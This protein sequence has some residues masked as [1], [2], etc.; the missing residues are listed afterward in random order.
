MPEPASSDPHQTCLHACICG[1][2]EAMLRDFFGDAYR[3]YAR[4][5]YIGI[6]LLH[7]AMKEVD[8]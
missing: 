8:A 1:A 5:T 2:Q 3:A 7:Y 6:P 4:R